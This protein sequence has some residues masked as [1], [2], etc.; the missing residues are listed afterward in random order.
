MQQSICYDDQCWEVEALFSRPHTGGLS[1]MS[2]ILKSSKSLLNLHR[3]LIWLYWNTICWESYYLQYWFTWNS[4]NL[5]LTKHKLKV[6]FCSIVTETTNWFFLIN[7]LAKDVASFCCMLQ[8]AEPQM[9]EWE[10]SLGSKGVQEINVWSEF[11]NPMSDVVSHATFRSSFS[12]GR[13]IIQLQIRAGTKHCKYNKHDAYPS[14]LVS[15]YKIY[16]RTW[17][18]YIEMDL[19]EQL[20]YPGNTSRCCRLSRRKIVICF[21]F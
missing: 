18:N 3:T 14:L 2:S 21:Y 15:S 7:C 16:F 17:G 8:W 11:Q 13:R 9:G 10:T 1:T 4:W 6:Q 5:C 19:P 12:E 20:A